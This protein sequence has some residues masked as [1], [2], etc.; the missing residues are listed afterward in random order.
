MCQLQSW[1]YWRSSLKSKLFKSPLCTNT[2]N[3]R[4]T[5][6]FKGFSL[7]KIQL[8]QNLGRQAV[9]KWEGRSS[10]SQPQKCPSPGAI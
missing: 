7:Y 6:L 2:M 5:L 8:T 4:V 10:S 1:R 3:K 9:L